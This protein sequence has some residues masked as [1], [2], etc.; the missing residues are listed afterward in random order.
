MGGSMIIF[1]FKGFFD[2]SFSQVIYFRPFLEKFFFFFLFIFICLKDLGG[3]PIEEPFASI[4]QKI[5]ILYFLYLS[6]IVFYIARVEIC[7]YCNLK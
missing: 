5:A 3:L 2:N 1:F 4:S 7:F 6:F